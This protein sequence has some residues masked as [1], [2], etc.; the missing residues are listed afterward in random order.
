MVPFITEDATVEQK[1]A[2]AREL[3]DEYM[4]SQRLQEIPVPVANICQQQQVECWHANGFRPWGGTRN[5][6]TIL[7]ST[8]T[9]TAS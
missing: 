7:F 8:A 6:R 9:G 2:T 4:S 1:C 5:G 3:L